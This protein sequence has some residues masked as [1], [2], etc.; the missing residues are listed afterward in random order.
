MPAVSRWLPPTRRLDLA[1]AI[2]LG[3]YAALA[4][5]SRGAGEVNVWVFLGL[6]GLA[7]A[8]VLGAWAQS[9]NLEGRALWVRLWGWAVLFRV[10]GLAGQPV[11]EDDW[12][13]YLWDGRVFAVEGNPYAKP[14]GAWF[15]D[16]TLPEPFQEVLDHIN[17][18][19]VPT[20]YGPVCQSAFLLAYWISPGSLWPL[21]LI[22]L[23][24]DLVTLRLLLNLTTPRNALLYGWCP[25]L[26]KETAFTAHPDSLGICFL[27]AALQ[28]FRRVSPAQVA[29]WCALAAGT[30]LFAWFVVPFLLGRT[31]KK[32]WL[33]G[34]SI[35]AALYLPFWLQ[36]SGA[37]LAGLRVFL[38]EWEF[39]S[40]LFAV[41]SWA[42]GTSW[43]KPLCGALFGL[44]WLWYLKK[45]SEIGKARPTLPRGDW[46]YGWFF[47]CSAVVNPWYLLWLLPF[48]TIGPSAWGI[49]A[50][51]AVNLSYVHGSNLGSDTLGSF[52]H[53][54]WVRPVELGVIGVAACWSGLRRRL[55]AKQKAL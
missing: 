28:A 5:L 27:V 52:Q 43:A 55:S 41:F 26:I 32:F 25:L 42:L 54:A 19:D 14:P 34:A 39:N 9:G 38:G 36:G 33:V 12:Y 51:V 2:S 17:Y 24:A 15:G 35:W 45:F 46:I 49:A 31:A 20:I 22:L 53:P 8:A 48:V 47:L 50:L 3:A 21:K 44:A 1:G 40:T 6:M 37:D 29:A 18:P 16:R 7:W 23:A 30:K 4:W 10:A 11:L 13:R